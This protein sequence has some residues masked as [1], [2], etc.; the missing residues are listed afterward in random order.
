MALP[1]VLNDQRK[2][3]IFHGHGKLILDTIVETEKGAIGKSVEKKNQRT[4]LDAGRHKRTTAEP[5]LSN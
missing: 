4:L 1:I 2:G 3:Y 5:H